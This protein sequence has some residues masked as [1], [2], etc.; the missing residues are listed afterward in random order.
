MK[1]MIYNSTRP[2]TAAEESEVLD[3]AIAELKANFDYVVEGF[4]KL[5]RDGKDGQ[6]RAQQI[7]LELSSAVEGAVASVAQSFTSGGAEE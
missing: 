7:L 3:D 5:G 2:V 1:R 6:N 4:E